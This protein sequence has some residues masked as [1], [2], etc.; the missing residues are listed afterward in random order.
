[1]KMNRCF[2][3]VLKA[4]AQEY[5]L[6]H[7]IDDDDPSMI[8]LNDHVKAW[9]I[10]A[11]TSYIIQLVTLTPEQKQELD[12]LCPLAFETIVPLLGKGSW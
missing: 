11:R 1:V 4:I 3:S 10:W 5:K 7:R 9:T 12:T 8:Q 2:P 6:S